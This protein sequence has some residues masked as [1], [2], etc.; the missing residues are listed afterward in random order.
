MLCPPVLF[1]TFTLMGHQLFD[2]FAET[3]PYFS[4]FGRPDRLDWSALS[5]L[6]SGRPKLL[7]LPEEGT[8]LRFE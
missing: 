2:V 3:L 6:M 1:L 4:L 8:L 5:S 7:L